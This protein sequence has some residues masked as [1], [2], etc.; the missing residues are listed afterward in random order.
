[1]DKPVPFSSLNTQCTRV[2]QYLRSVGP[3]VFDGPVLLHIADG[4]MVLALRAYQ[5]EC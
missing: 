5:F 2:L 1:M 3:R 4:Y